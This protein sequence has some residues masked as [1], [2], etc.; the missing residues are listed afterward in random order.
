MNL[1]IQKKPY[2]NNDN[3]TVNKKNVLIIDAMCEVRALTK[4]PDNSKT[5]IL[6]ELFIQRVKLK[7]D[8]YPEA[9][10]LFDT[11][12]EIGDFILRFEHK[13]R[14]QNALG[15]TST[16]NYEIQDEMSIKKTSL[17]ELYISTETKRRL[18]KY[19]AEGL[20]LEYKD[21]PI[22]TIIVSYGTTIA[23]N[24]PHS[25]PDTLTSHRHEKED[26]QIPLLSCSVLRSML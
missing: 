16:G 9:H 19:F 24:E 11:Y 20:L 15:I 8:K 21:D 5:S 25:L 18:T 23:I 3:N 1:I 10:L 4:Y 14:A 26:T 17:N 2:K 6:K 13:E 7:I 22:H 12:R